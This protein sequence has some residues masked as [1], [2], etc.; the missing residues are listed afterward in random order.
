MKTVAII[1]GLVALVAADCNIDNLKKCSGKF[2]ADVGVSGLPQSPEALAADL[3]KLLAKGKSGFEQICTAG[4]NSKKCLGAEES[5]CMTPANLAKIGITKP[6]NA[7]G[8]ISIYYGFGYMCQSGFK[9]VED[10]L[11]CI[12]KVHVAHKQEFL[13]CEHDFLAVAMSSPAKI[14][15]A[16]LTYR[17]CVSAPYIK[18]CNQQVA[19]VMGGA[20]AAGLKATA[21]CSMSKRSLSSDLE[22]L[23]HKLCKQCH[24]TVHSV[25][26]SLRDPQ[27]HDSAKKSLEMLC[28]P[29]S[30]ISQEKHD[31]CI[32][33]IDTTVEDFLTGATDRL[34]P[35]KLCKDIHICQ[36]EDSK[37]SIKDT[38]ETL[39]EK[40]EELKKK[41]EKLAHKLEMSAEDAVDNVEEALKKLKEQARHQM[42]DLEQKVCL[43][44]H[45][46]V[47]KA[48]AMLADSDNQQRARETVERVCKIFQIFQDETRYQTCIDKVDQSING[49]M[50]GAAKRLEPISLCQS[51]HVCKATHGK[52]S[53]KDTWDK[54]TNDI[55]RMAC[56]C[57]HSTVDKVDHM[58]SDPKNARQTKKMLKKICTLFHYIGLESVYERC[59]VDSDHFMNNVIIGVVDG[60][61]SERFCQKIHFCK[62][63]HQ[64]RSI[65]ES[66]EGLAQKACKAC[67]TRVSKVERMLSDP[68]TADTGRQTLEYFCRFYQIIGD[69]KKF[70]K[71]VRTV[72]SSVEHFLQGATDEL[73]PSKFC[74]EIHV[75]Q[76]ESKRSISD[77]V[78]NLENQANNMLNNLEEKAC[79]ACHKY[80]GKADAILADPDNQQQAREQI[81]RFCAIFQIFQDQTRY[82]A[83][84]QTVDQCVDS[85]LTG[86]AKHLEP[87][88][89][90]QQIHV[91]KEQQKRSL[92]DVIHQV[93]ENLEEMACDA[94]QTEAKKV[95][96]LIKNPKNR[97]TVHRTLNRLCS[98]YNIIGDKKNHDKCV[99]K[100]DQCVD[101]TLDKFVAEDFCQEIHLCETS[102]NKR[103]LTINVEQIAK[104]VCH[105]CQRYVTAANKYVT[106]ISRNE[107]QVKATLE[108]ACMIYNILGQDQKHDKCINTI[109]KQVDQIVSGA[110]Q[111]LE[112]TR[113]C[114][115]IHLCSA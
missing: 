69:Q 55:S 104:K 34:E 59:V 95:E 103:S 101:D 48:D 106:D 43:A 85:V 93:E 3:E 13:K 33:K 64:K 96:K 18:E 53:I 54:T 11:D 10:N 41:A 84:I 65:L 29:L 68:K 2:F 26:Q 77:S 32:T 91:C 75:C 28:A 112:P 6:E 115:E 62:A 16:G 114:Q 30:I 14:C 31:K 89:F 107:E 27:H 111:F 67:K 12:M 17:K 36:K 24:K 105:T 98:F 94:C 92:T 102:Q 108:Q 58:L 49:I 63:D 45:T 61:E 82:T 86:A 71:C 22:T 110:T 42:D 70:D 83:C 5:A 100:V 1:L 72:D 9:V 87:T 35:G 47:G 76:S 39:E 52:R 113:L 60:L 25:E 50:T 15:D 40:A 73:E 80:V 97:G 23:A 57:C 44:C 8:I 109:E 81:E 37:R 66:L 38:M 56:D 4:L 88:T 78:H 20:I 79:Q 21:G 7:F 46:Y 90:C 99:R 74:H 19:D 51:M